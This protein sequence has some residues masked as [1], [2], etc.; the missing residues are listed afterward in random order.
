M[1]IQYKC[2]LWNE[3][4]LIVIRCD[5]ALG[6]IFLIFF[7][8]ALDALLG[9]CILNK[10]HPHHFSCYLFGKVILCRS[11]T[12]GKDHNIRPVQCR[13]DHCLHPFFIVSYHTLI[14]YSQTKVRTFHCRYA[15]LV[16]TILPSNIS[17]PTVTI[18]AIIFF[19]FAVIIP[20]WIIRSYSP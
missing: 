17:V 12:T 15:P 13:T 14:I 2:P 3:C 9:M 16:F 11:K 7:H 19:P 8:I 6:I 1:I 4:L 18:S 20:A 10:R 5:A